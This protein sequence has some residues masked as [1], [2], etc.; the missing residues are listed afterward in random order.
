VDLILARHAESKNN[1]LPSER[2]GPDPELTELGMRQAAA[3]A[4]ALAAAAPDAVLCSPLLRSLE[5]ARPAVAACGAPWGVWADLAE[6]GRAHPGDG[7]PAAVL[8]A[9]FPGAGFEPG[10]PWP[11]H[12]G[13]ESPA[14][15]AA[16]AARVLGRL[17]AA[18]PSDARVA[19]IGHGGFNPYLVRACLG[20]PQDGSVLIAQDNA[21]IH[22][23]ELLRGPGAV[24]LTRLND[25]SHL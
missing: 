4:R 14:E 2:H 5:T 20:A 9:R 18:F 19:V 8:R 12:P 15:A 13:V 24:R 22:R 17:L 23:L 6:T 1:V 3:L 7:Q 11:G 25:R 16:R 10:M 21:A